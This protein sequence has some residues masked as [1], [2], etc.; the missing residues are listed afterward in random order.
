M[1]LFTEEQENNIKKHLKMHKTNAISAKVLNEILLDTINNKRKP[2]NNA[3]YPSREKYD[4]YFKL[5]IE[6]IDCDTYKFILIGKHVS[7]NTY[8]GFASMGKRSSYKKAIKNAAYHYTLI[9]RKKYKAILPSE[10]FKKSIITPIAY[11]PKSRDDDGCAVTIKTFRDCLTIY[12]F[13]EDDKRINVTQN[14]TQEVI[15]KD[16]KIELILQRVS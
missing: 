16:Y 6:K 9:N 14:R 2:S 4:F 12:K 7:T 13:I 3:I 1:T 10:P 5:D 8:N 11:N 15:S